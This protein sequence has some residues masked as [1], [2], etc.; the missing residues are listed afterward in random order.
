MRGFCGQ[1]ALR[2]EQE[3]VASKH[4]VCVKKS[5]STRL[6]IVPLLLSHLLQHQKSFWTCKDVG[7]RWLGGS[8]PSPTLP[9]K[10]FPPGNCFPQY[11]RRRHVLSTFS[12]FCPPRKCPFLIPAKNVLFLFPRKMSISYSSCT[13]FFSY[14]PGNILFSY[15]PGTVA[16]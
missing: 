3:A 4:V 5:C 8:P 2:I 15:Y 16:N 1:T 13:L 7:F 10:R 9:R 6:E 12:V 11:Y 14:S